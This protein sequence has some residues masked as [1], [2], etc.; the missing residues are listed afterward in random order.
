[1]AAAPGDNSSRPVTAVILAAGQSKRMKSDLVKVLHKVCDRPMLAW[2]IDAC[3]AAGC[4]TIHLVVGHQSE[5]VEAAFGDDPS[6][7]FVHQHERLGTGHAV[8]QA[9]PLLEDFDGDVFVLAGDGPLIRTSTLQTLLE[10][11]RASQAGAT[12]ATSEVEDPTGYGRIVRDDDG[13]FAS[14]V[15]HKDANESQRAIRE[16]NPSYYCFDNRRLFDALSRVTNDNASGE[17]YITDVLEI[18]KND[19][20]TIEVIAAVDPS[21]VL[22]INTMEQLAQVES[23]LTRRLTQESIT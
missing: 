18:L 13:S 11:H 7:R 6:I 17:Y 2:V 14:I 1:M 10:R 16:I 22:S 20:D 9:A 3:R 12:M 23:I 19:G 5:Q 8:Q 21:D 4:E 15:E